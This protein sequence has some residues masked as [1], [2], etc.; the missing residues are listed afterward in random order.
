MKRIPIIYTNWNH[1]SKGS[2]NA[3]PMLISCSNLILK[4][5]KGSAIIQFLLSQ[6]ISTMPRRIKNPL[7]ISPFSYA[8]GHHSYTWSLSLS[9]SQLWRLYGIN[10]EQNGV[11]MSSHV[12]KVYKQRVVCFGPG[13]WIFSN[14]NLIC[15][16]DLSPLKHSL[17][18]Y[19]M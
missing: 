2:R 15:A 13:S 8:L 6:Y 11:G 18:V 5:R 7:A 9:L 3:D 10:V 4:R 14:E 12:D 19:F 17:E 1:F 16:L